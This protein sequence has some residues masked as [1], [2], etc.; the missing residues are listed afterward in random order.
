MATA[1]CAGKSFLKLRCCC[2]VVISSESRGEKGFS[3]T[4]RSD[5][6][7]IF[8]FGLFKRFDESGFVNIGVIFRPDFFKVGNAVGDD[9]Q[10]GKGSWHST[11][12]PIKARS[13]KRNILT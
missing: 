10:N 7:R 13:I 1:V 9:F 12:I 3:E 6:E 4:T 11:K 2:F 8:E 5:D